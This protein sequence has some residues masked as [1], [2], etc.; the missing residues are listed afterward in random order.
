[1]NKIHQKIE[2]FLQKYKLNN[3]NEIYIVAFSGGFDSICLLNSLKKLPK[4]ELLHFT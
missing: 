3:P 4:I 1:M 2:L